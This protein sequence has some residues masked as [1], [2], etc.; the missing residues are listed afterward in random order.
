MKRFRITR[1]AKRDLDDI[2]FYIAR[3][4]L[5]AANKVC[6]EIDRTIR[7]IARFPGIGRAPS[8]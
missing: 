6:D 5:D 7:L 1:Q 4:S 3:D 8:L 2:W